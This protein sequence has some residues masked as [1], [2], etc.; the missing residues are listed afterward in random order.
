MVIARTL[1]GAVGVGMGEDTVC[2]PAEIQRSRMQSC[3]PRC[4]GSRVEQ[5]NQGIPVLLAW[6]HARLLLLGSVLDAYS[7]V[8]LLLDCKANHSS[9]GTLLE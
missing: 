1:R 5:P 2:I 7:D 3:V 6:M 4:K 9:K 8:L